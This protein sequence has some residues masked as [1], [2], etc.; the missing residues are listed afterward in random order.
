MYTQLTLSK[1]DLT[2][3]L[4]KEP[5]Y[6]SVMDK[7]RKAGEVKL[8]GFL[9]FLAMFSSFELPEIT[10]ADFVDKKAIMRI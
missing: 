7:Y 4:K 8:P 2:K 6:G 1:Q 9:R 5:G 10:T 3:K